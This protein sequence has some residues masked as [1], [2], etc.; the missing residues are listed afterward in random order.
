MIHR[1]TGLA[2]LCLVVVCIL[3]LLKVVRFIEKNRLRAPRNQ[4]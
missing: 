3:I 4:V 1:L 2:V